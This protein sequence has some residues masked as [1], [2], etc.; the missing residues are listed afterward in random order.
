MEKEFAEQWSADDKVVRQKLSALEERFGKK[1]NVVFILA[2]DVGYTELGSYG[3]GKLR[4]APTN[5]LDKMAQQGMR[6]LNFYSEVECSPSRGAVTTGRHPIRNGLYNITLPGEVGGGLAEEEVTTAEVLSEVGYY[7]GFFG[8]W[9]MGGEEE[10]WPTSQ[11]FDEAEWSEG[12]PPWWVNNQNAKASDDI[13]GFTNRAL[14]N[15][16]GPENFPYDTGG[17]MRAIKGE[18]PEMVYEYS[19]EKYNTYDSEVADKVIDFINRRAKTDQP[20]Y[21]NF[22]GKGNHFWGAHPDFRDTPAQTNTAAQ[23]VE[24]DYNVGRVLKTLTDLGIAENTLVIWASDN[25]PMYTVHPHGGY[26]LLPGTKGETRE[27]GVH[28]PALA[29]WP[30]MIE[31]GQDPLDIIQI[32]DIFMTIASLAD[33]TDEIPTDRVIDGVDQSGL[34][35]MGEGKGRRGYIFQY[36]RTNLE[37]VRKDQIKINLKPRNPDF[38]FFEVYNIYHDP[39]ERFPNEIQNGMWAGPGMTKMVQDHMKQIQKYP[40]RE[41]RSYYRDFDRSFDPEPSPVYTPGKTVDW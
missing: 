32:T 23:M 19:M 13:G 14:V 39:A 9:H 27:G 12:N 1:P 4:G 33:A 5:N 36:N 18:E 35:L 17:V 28:V 8:K 31:A 25:G 24:H 10:H 2:D 20:F 11:G 6:F 41:V 37:A 26:S 30:G 16:P 7:T 29:W 21:V 34:L 22:W 38:H 15:S 40:H 3:G